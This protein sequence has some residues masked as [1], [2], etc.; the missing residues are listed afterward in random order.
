LQ[1]RNQ[2]R[3]SARKDPQGRVGNRCIRSHQ[4]ICLHCSLQCLEHKFHRIPRHCRY[5]WPCYCSNR[6]C[7]SLSSYWDRFVCW[8]HT[9]LHCW[10]KSEMG[11]CTPCIQNHQ[12]CRTSDFKVSSL[13][14]GSCI[15]GHSKEDLFGSHYTIQSEGMCSLRQTNIGIES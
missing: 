14:K 3:D 13:L 6:L 7:H 8:F 1:L 2:I 12:L 10:C 15:R 11:E 5:E 4:W 9:R